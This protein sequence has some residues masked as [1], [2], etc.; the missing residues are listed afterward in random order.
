[1][2]HLT[3]Y[4]CVYQPKYL[5]IDN[6]INYRLQIYRNQPPPNSSMLRNVT[7]ET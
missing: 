4:D 7:L 1:M 6:Y 3:P 5:I 2:Q